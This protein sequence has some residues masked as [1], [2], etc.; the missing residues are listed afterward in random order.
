MA[1]GADVR[2]YA[3]SER[4]GIEDAAR[5]VR[6]PSCIEADGPGRRRIALGHTRDDQAET[7]LLKLIRGAGPTALGDPSASDALVRPPRRLARRSGEYLRDAGGSVGR[8]RIER[9]L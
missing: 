8:G 6:T 2:E 1:G 4:L 9:R 5:R 7:S 3:A